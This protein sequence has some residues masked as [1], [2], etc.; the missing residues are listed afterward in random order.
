[1]CYHRYGSTLE[2]HVPS[3]Y[4]SDI[5]SL[6]PEKKV[7]LAH[8]GK[9]LLPRF[10]KYMHDESVSKLTELGVNV[11]LGSRVDLSSVSPSPIVEAERTVRTMAGETLGAEYIVSK[12]ATR[13]GSTFLMRLYPAAVV[14]WSEAQCFSSSRPPSQLYQPREWCCLCDTY[15]AACTCSRARR[16]DYWPCDVALSPHLRS[17]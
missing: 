9:Q 3:E 2:P 17:W 6:Y 4:A 14:H 11:V 10:E 15:Y 7:T 16:R 5:A 1:V 13:K 8:S 12:L